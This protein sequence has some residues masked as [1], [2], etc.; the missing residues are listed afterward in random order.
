[1]LLVE[2]SLR[3]AGST[4]FA[5]APKFGADLFV[6]G[7]IALSQGFII[8][9]MLLSAIVAFSIDHSFLKAALWAFAGAILSAIGIIHAYAL[10]PQGVQ[11]KF[12]VLEA[13]GFVVGYGLTGIAL[14]ALYL[15]Q[16]SSPSSATVPAP[17]P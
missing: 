2:I 15:R 17:R 10:T 11:N 3:A 4:L 12:G 13:P 14:L 5:A 7:V 1:L 8:T 16:P 6:H 9:S